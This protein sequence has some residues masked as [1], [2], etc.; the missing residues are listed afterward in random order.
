MKSRGK[1]PAFHDVRNLIINPENADAIKKY[2]QD[3]K[4]SGGGW[5]KG[6]RKLKRRYKKGEETATDEFI[7]S[8]YTDK[9]QPSARLHEGDVSGKSHLKE[10]VISK[11]SDDIVEDDND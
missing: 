5:R 3:L 11:P 8:Q 2:K 10:K 9:P 6:F 4:G 7:L 1:K